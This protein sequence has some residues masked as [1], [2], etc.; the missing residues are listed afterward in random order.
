MKIQCKYTATDAGV[1]GRL[2]APTFIGALLFIAAQLEWWE[3]LDCSTSLRS[4]DGS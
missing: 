1:V 2:K 4:L 3:W